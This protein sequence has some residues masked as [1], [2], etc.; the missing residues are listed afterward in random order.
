LL[1]IQQNKIEQLNQLQY[2]LDYVIK[3]PMT[4]ENI[5]EKAI[6]QLKLVELK[7]LQEA[8]RN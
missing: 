2:S 7:P 1:K 5:R 8:M 4:P 3:D 6:M